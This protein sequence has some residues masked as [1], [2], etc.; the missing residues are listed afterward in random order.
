M[1]FGLRCIAH[2]GGRLPGVAAH[3]ICLVLSIFF[4]I[5][6]LH[7]RMRGSEHGFRLSSLWPPDDDLN[8]IVPFHVIIDFSHLSIASSISV[9]ID[10]TLFVMSPWII[11]AHES[12][13]D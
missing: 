9:I 5:R 12:M 11:N 6:T 2:F 4:G 13:D 1:R 7:V 10:F 8:F 3:R